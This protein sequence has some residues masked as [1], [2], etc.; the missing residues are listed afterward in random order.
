MCLSVLLNINVIWGPIVMVSTIQFW[1]LTLS[2]KTSV[3]LCAFVCLHVCHMDC[4]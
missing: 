3:H 4:I 1:T 2:F